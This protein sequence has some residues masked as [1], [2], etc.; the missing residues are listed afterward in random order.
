MTDATGPAVVVVGADGQAVSVAVG[1]LRAE[2][3]RVAGF[4]GTDEAAARAMGAELFA[5]EPVEL[6]RLTPSERRRSD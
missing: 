3:H 1:R 5:G 4:V 6:R 2:G